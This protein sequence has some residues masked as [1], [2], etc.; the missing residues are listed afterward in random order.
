M[1]LVQLLPI[2]SCNSAL[3]NTLHSTAP[4]MLS[5]CR[6]LPQNAV[7]VCIHCMATVQLVMR[8]YP[9]PTLVGAAALQDTRLLGSAGLKHTFLCCCC[10][11]CNPMLLLLLLLLCAMLCCMVC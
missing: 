7:S 11:C 4:V 1:L 10:C 2:R 6:V 3:H 9:Q 5:D 8:A